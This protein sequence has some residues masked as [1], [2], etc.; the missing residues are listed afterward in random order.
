MQE[1]DALTNGTDASVCTVTK[2]LGD[3]TKIPFDCTYLP[4][5]KLAL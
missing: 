2:L 4:R 1:R 5:N 3:Y